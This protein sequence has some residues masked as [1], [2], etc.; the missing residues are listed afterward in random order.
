MVH[1]QDLSITQALQVLEDFWNSMDAKTSKEAV[2]SI[3]GASLSL[4]QDGAVPMLILSRCGWC[5]KTGWPV[6]A[7]TVCVVSYAE[8]MMKG[9]ARLVVSELQRFLTYV[10]MIHCGSSVQKPAGVSEMQ[11]LL[12]LARR[13]PW[14]CIDKL[15]GLNGHSNVSL[16]STVC[17]VPLLGASVARD[18]LMDARVGVFQTLPLHKDKVWRAIYDLLKRAPFLTGDHSIYKVMFGPEQKWK[19]GPGC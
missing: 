4:H 5:T 7:G 8:I 10:A 14:M 19:P 18:V 16:G 11:Y 6:F 9:M 1:E 2:V 13:F 3:L 15:F 17:M 12:D